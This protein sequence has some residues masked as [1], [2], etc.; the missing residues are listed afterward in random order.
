MLMCNCLAEKMK[1]THTYPYVEMRIKICEKNS[2]GKKLVRN[3]NRGEREDFTTTATA[4]V[5]MEEKRMKTAS[6]ILCRAH[7]AFYK[8]LYL[9]CALCRTFFAIYLYIYFIHNDIISLIVT[10]VPSS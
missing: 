2:C 6:Y 9:M 3:V 10:S 8:N 4:T 5:K 1:T 7:K